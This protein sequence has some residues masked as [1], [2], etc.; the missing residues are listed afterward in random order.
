[1]VCTSC[2]LILVGNAVTVLRLPD[3]LK[4]SSAL[5]TLCIYVFSSDDHNKDVIYSAECNRLA[6]IMNMQ[7]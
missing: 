6:C 5:S 1:M 4:K 2:V 3:E 7:Y